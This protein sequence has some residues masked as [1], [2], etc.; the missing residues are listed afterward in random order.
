MALLIE[1]DRFFTQQ[2]INSPTRMKKIYSLALATI[3]ALS[4]SALG[5]AQTII[6]QIAEKVSNPSYELTETLQE[7]KEL[8]PLR[9]TIDNYIGEYDWNYG[10]AFDGKAYTG[11]VTITK[12]SADKSVIVHFETADG[13]D[14][15]N[16]NGTVNSL[17]GV[18]TLQ[19]TVVGS[20]SDGTELKFYG[21]TIGENELIKATI[22]ATLNEKTR[23]VTFDR[24]L[25][26]FLST[27]ELFAQSRAYTG[28]CA[29]T[30]T[31]PSNWQTLGTGKFKDAFLA[32]MYGIP[33]SS[34]PEVDV[35]VLYDANNEGMFRIVDPFYEVFG[36][37]GTFEI[38][39]TDQEY[40][41]IP[42][43]STFVEDEDY[44]IVYIMSRSYAHAYLLNPTLDK[45]EFLE[46]YGDF[47]ITYDKA[48][49][50]IDI[51]ENSFFI[52]WP[53]SPGDGNNGPSPNGLY[54]NN[55][56]S[57]SYL[58]LP[59]DPA[60]IGN[61][62]ADADINAPVE[63]FNLQGMKIEN[64]E[65]GQIVIRRQGSTVTKMLTR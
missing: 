52:R 25:Y 23:T 16:V 32:T 50:R 2:L 35:T 62:A 39:A 9:V 19:E 24:S 10:G 17:T 47:N 54:T 44:G 14:I 63:Y 1:A 27:D 56:S 12:G 11:S 18:L 46:T 22:T 38:N 59:T 7:S 6:P 57:E 43:Q 28:T 26:F 15:F 65:A 37:T 30:F 40:V 33:V 21:A 55:K 48:T 51:P 34:C 8:S 13:E 36:V 29:N 20:L 53:S 45:K 42:Q 58:I 49:G 61:I 41:L 31:I 3:C 64:P 4:A 60:A 5:P